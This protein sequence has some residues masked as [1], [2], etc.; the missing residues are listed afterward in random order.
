M[1]YREW[2]D[3]ASSS[4][5]AMPKWYY[6]RVATIVCRREVKWEEINDATKAFGQP[7]P[8]GGSWK[9]VKRSLVAWWRTKS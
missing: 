6:E 8:E 2:R 9:D 7:A 3:I 1:T 5:V 4:C